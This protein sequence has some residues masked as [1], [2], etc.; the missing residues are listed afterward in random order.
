[1]LLPC[2]VYNFIQWN[3]YEQQLVSFSSFYGAQSDFTYLD[4]RRIK[5]CAVRYSAVFI[6]PQIYRDLSYMLQKCLQRQDYAGYY[7]DTKLCHC[8]SKTFSQ[9]FSLFTLMHGPNFWQLDFSGD[10]LGIH[11]GNPVIKLFKQFNYLNPIIKCPRSFPRVTPA[12][13]HRLKTC[14][15]GWLLTLDCL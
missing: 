11:N 8:L 1:M 12:H 14:T 15:L 2:N 13:M 4:N 3:I 5:S 9:V 6:H 10:P 7:G